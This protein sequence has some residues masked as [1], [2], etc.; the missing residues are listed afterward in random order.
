MQDDCWVQVKWL[1]HAGSITGGA[2]DVE[3]TDLDM[4][5]GICGKFKKRTF[6][7]GS[8]LSQRPYI[9]N[10]ILLER[11]SVRIHPCTSSL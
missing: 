7:G 1:S 10:S 2:Q 5:S 11:S 4:S 9:D 8:A 6:E 3:V